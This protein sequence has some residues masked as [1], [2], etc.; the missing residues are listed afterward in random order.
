MIAI[1]LG[2]FIYLVA[3]W[4]S[5]FTDYWV[6]AQRSLMVGLWEDM[7]SW[8]WNPVNVIQSKC[9]YSYLSGHVIVGFSGISSV[10]RSS[11][12]RAVFTDTLLSTAAVL[13]DGLCQ[14]RRISEVRDRIRVRAPQLPVSECIFVKSATLVC[15]MDLSVKKQNDVQSVQL[16]SLFSA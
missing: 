7:G 13:R 6:C 1:S 14:S 2:L 5:G 4:C 9:L 11:S 15:S 16:W 8:R 10:A 3:T 12:D